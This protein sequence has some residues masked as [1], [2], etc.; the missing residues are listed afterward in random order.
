[1]EKKRIVCFGD[2][3]TWGYDAKTEWRL[4]DEVRWT[5]R[6]QRLLG[7]G[8]T[9][10]EEGLN[11]RTTVFEDPL[12]EGLCAISAVQTVF[13]SQMPLDMAIVML[14][15]ND[16]KER[17][18]ATPQNIADGLRRLLVKILNM[19]QVWR[20]EPK[21][22]VVAPIVMAKELYEKGCTASRIGK[23]CVEKSEKL[24]E[25]QK[26]VAEELGLPFMDCNEYVTPNRYDF[27]HFDE[28]SHR[29]FA[30]AVLQR[31]RELC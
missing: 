11:G 19:E 12:T 25:L 2:S 31:V 3:N 10:I 28:D 13:L 29:T 14:G 17:F 1:M 7:E 22:L 20:G 16:C 26:N 5:T 18:S 27:M 8:Y 30:Q 9:I 23:G 4:P 24:P 21:V 6:L 15:T